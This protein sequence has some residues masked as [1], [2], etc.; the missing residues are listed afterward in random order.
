MTILRKIFGP[1]IP[2][3]YRALVSKWS[4]DPLFR[5]AFTAYRTGVLETVFDR[6]LEPVNDSLYFAGESMNSS[7][8]GYTHSGYGSGAY[9]AHHIAQLL[10]P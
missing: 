6:L 7:D 8:Y 1:G 4:S 2:D 3:P 5:C 10:S 9:V